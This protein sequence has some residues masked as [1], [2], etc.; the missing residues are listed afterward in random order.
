MKSGPDRLIVH[1]YEI[2]EGRKSK[3]M[4]QARSGTEEALDSSMVLSGT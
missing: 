3:Y 4:F 1:A 2:S